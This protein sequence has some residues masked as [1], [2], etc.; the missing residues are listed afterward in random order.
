MKEG[1]KI[2]EENRAFVSLAFAEERHHGINVKPEF[3]VNGPSVP[4]LIPFS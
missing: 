3:N 2:N 4:E 1:K